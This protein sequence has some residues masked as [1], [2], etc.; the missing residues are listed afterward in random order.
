MDEIII[1]TKNKT[2]PVHVD[3]HVK[4]MM[5]GRCMLCDVVYV[6]PITC[7]HVITPM[8]RDTIITMG[9]GVEKT[10]LVGILSFKD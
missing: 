4:S 9:G 2:I 10:P 7:C 8:D 6:C 5:G 3:M 1:P